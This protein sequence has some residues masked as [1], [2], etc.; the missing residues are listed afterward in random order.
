MMPPTSHA[1]RTRVGEWREARV[2]PEVV[3]TPAPSMLA[4][5]RKVSVQ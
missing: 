5:T 2:K 3:K 4:I 1:R